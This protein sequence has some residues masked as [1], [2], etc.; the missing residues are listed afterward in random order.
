MC[1]TAG[2]SCNGSD[3]VLSADGT[4]H[5]S[6]LLEVVPPPPLFLLPP[7]CTNKSIIG[8]TYDCCGVL[9]GCG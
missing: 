9:C 5:Q 7:T 8:H 1:V 4:P 6:V 2:C 3:D